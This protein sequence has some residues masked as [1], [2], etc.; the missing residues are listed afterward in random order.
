[1]TRAAAATA[2][3][4]LAGVQKTYRSPAGRGRGVG[5]PALRGVDLVIGAG[6][7]VAV[8]GPSGSGKTT[9][10]NLIAGI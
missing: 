4:E 1:M 6:E 3:I 2:I 8:T 7:M 10:I 5:F 9:I